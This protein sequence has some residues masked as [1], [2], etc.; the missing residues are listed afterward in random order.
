MLIVRSVE[1]CEFNRLL[2]IWQSGSI[3]QY[4]LSACFLLFNQIQGQ[5]ICMRGRIY[6][7]ISTDFMFK[8]LTDFKLANLEKVQDSVWIWFV[9]F[10][11]KYI[12]T[13]GDEIWMCGEAF[14][15]LLSWRF[16]KLFSQFPFYSPKLCAIAHAGNTVIC[17]HYRIRYWSPEPNVCDKPQQLV[18]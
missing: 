9:T 6:L 13:A 16:L 10:T 8:N 11:N 12:D 4:F 17:T 7:Q 1:G 18:E 2:C 3:W 5:W 14:C 15:G